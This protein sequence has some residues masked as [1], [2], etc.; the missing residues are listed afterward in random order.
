LAPCSLVAASCLCLPQWTAKEV[1]RAHA[2]EANM[3]VQALFCLF[4]RTNLQSSLHLGWHSSRRQLSDRL[5]LTSSYIVSSFPL[6]LETYK[7]LF[8]VQGEKP[9]A[10]NPQSSVDGFK[11]GVTKPN[12][13]QIFEIFGPRCRICWTLNH[14]SPS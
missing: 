4:V 5:S 9:R 7:N 8:L 11:E 10:Y 3:Y 6:L 1:G 13:Q 14:L 12:S 2:S